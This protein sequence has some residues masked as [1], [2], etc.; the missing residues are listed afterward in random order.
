MKVQMMKASEV[1]ADAIVAIMPCE[2]LPKTFVLRI[3]RPV[4]H[5]PTLLIDRLERARKA[6]F[7]REL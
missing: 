7:R 2:H 5:E 3:E 1:T 4:T 6:I